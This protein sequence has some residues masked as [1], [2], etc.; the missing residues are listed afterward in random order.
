MLFHLVA[1]FDGGTPLA[2]FRSGACLLHTNRLSLEYGISLSS[3]SDCEVLLPLFQRLFADS[4]SASGRPPV[5]KKA[6]I[7]LV[8]N[9]AT[10]LARALDGVFA[11]AFIDPAS[12]V[13]VIARDP[14]G[15]RPLYTGVLPDG[16]RVWASEMKAILPSG[17]AGAAPFPPGHVG[18]YDLATGS[19]LALAR[20]HA[21]PWIKNPAYEEAVVARAHV[22]S[23][24]E[25]AV[26]KR[27]LSDRPIGCLLSGGL[28]SSLVSALVQRALRARGVTAPLRT[29][30]IGMSAAP[31]TDLWFARQVATFIGSEHHGKCIVNLCGSICVMPRCNQHSQWHRL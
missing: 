27:L 13:V 20:Y 19:E 1:Y 29:F 22:R 18:V 5:D 9:A 14:Y 17:T 6:R 4:V 31:G 11:I 26:E 15:V 7:A 28:D 24:L 3:G 21:V 30:A 23:A 16:G 25:A 12:G 2:T 8:L 10:Q